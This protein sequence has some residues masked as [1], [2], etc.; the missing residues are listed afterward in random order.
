VVLVD[1]YEGEPIAQGQCSQAFRLRY[2]DP[3]RTLTDAEV[4]ASH[5]KVREALQRQFAAELRS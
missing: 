3:Q 4:E 5:Q 2:R 1:R